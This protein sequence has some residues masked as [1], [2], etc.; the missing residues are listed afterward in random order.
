MRIPGGCTFWNF[1][2]H[3]LTKAKSILELKSTLALGN[4]SLKIVS[5]FDEFEPNFRYICR[6]HFTP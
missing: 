2:F 6:I 3:C 1:C 4:N 5:L